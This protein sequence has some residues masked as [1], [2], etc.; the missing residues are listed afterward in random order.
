VR[1]FL[2]EEGRVMT[3]GI[4][5]PMSAKEMESAIMFTAA[6]PHGITS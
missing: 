5:Q 6:A 4:E 2:R 3:G 1:D